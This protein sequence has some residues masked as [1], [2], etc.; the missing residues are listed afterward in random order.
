MRKNE[1]AHMGQ[2]IRTETSPDRSSHKGKSDEALMGR[3]MRGGPT[4]LSHSLKGNSSQ[5]HMHPGATSKGK[6]GI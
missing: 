4:D 1:K 6:K 3:S 2:T 5:V